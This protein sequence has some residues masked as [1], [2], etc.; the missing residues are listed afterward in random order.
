MRLHVWGA[1]ACFTRPEFKAERVSYDVITPS[2]ARGSSTPSAGSRGLAGS[3]IASTCWMPVRFETVCRNEVGRKVPAR[4][5]AGAMRRGTTDGLQLRIED[6]RLHRAT[7]L[8][9]DVAYVIAARCQVCAPARAREIRAKHLAMFDRR[10]GRGQ[11]FHRPYLGMRALSTCR[12]PTM[13]G[14]GDERALGAQCAL[15][16]P[17]GPRRGRAVRV[18]ARAHRLRARALRCGRAGRRVAVVRW[19]RRNPPCRPCA[20]SRTRCGAR[21]ARRRNSSGTRR[22]TCSGSSVTPRRASPVLRPESTRHLRRCMSGSSRTP[23]TKGSGRCFASSAHGT[24]STMTPF[25]MRRRCSTERS[26]SG[27]RATTAGC[28][29]VPHRGRCGRS[30]SPPARA[31]RACVPPAESVYRSHACI[32]RCAVSGGSH[33]RQLGETAAREFGIDVNA[34]VEVGGWGVIRRY[35]ERGIGI[36]VVPSVCLHETDEVSVIALRQ[37]VGRAALAC[38]G[39]AARRCRRL[40]GPCSGCCYRGVRNRSVVGGRLGERMR[41]G[42]EGGDETPALEAGA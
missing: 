28:T 23:A 15:R 30:N 20:R 22:R 7:T 16:A 18:R 26:S 34:V 9:H 17:A 39:G 2:A 31:P 1:Y 5:A 38:T 35:V 36:C 37:H 19:F 8:L 25:P 21:R 10:A 3:S 33:S 14:S 41:Q 29:S 6:E 40:R 12:R 4:A 27:S 13:Y 11:C 42:R 32:Q 24:D